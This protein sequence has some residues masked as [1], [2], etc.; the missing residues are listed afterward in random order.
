MK[1]GEKKLK[2]NGGYCILNK[3][4]SP[5]DFAGTTEIKRING[6]Y[7]CICRNRDSTKGFY[8]SDENGKP[9]AVSPLLCC[10]FCGRIFNKN[11]LEI[12]RGVYI[13]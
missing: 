1:D 7:R 9:I 2:G 12:V 4:I 10:Y 6:D 8:A 3:A 13:R 5:I 11:T